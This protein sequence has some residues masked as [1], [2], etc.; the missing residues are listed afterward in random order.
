M[1][2]DRMLLFALILR[3][4]LVASSWHLLV[5]LLPYL[6]IITLSTCQGLSLNTTAFAY[7]TFNS[8]S[9]DISLLTFLNDSRV[10]GSTVLLNADASSATPFRNYT[11]GK[12][13]YTQ[14]VQMRV[15]SNTT[16]PKSVASFNTCFTFSITGEGSAGF[17]FLIATYDHYNFSVTGAG[18]ASM[19]VLNKTHNGDAN[20]HVFA[21]EFDTWLNPEFNDPSDNHI[22]VNVNS[23]NSTA[24]YNLCGIATYCLHLISGDDFTTWIDYDGESQALEVRFTNGSTLQGVARPATPIITVKSLDLSH[25]VNDYMHVGFSGSVGNEPE[26]HHIKSWSFQSSSNSVVQGAGKSDPRVALIAGLA[27]GAALLILVTGLAAAYLL[28][29]RRRAVVMSTAKQAQGQLA[30]GAESTDALDIKMQFEQQHMWLRR[31]T[32]EELSSATNGFSED[33]V[34]GK[35]GYGQVFMG[36][37]RD[38]ES[39]NTI[40]VAMKRMLQTSAQ[41]HV[42]RNFLAEVSIISQIRHRNLVQLYGWCWENEHLLLVYEYMPNNSL[43]K[44]ILPSHESKPVLTWEK[45]HHIMMGVAAAVTY[46]HNGWKKRVLHRD[47]KDSN[48]LLDEEFNAHLGDFGL[49]RFMNHSVTSKQTH[50]AGTFGY[51][52]PEMAHT[53]RTTEKSDVFSFGVLALVVACGR[54]ALMDSTLSE[55]QEEEEEEEYTTLVDFV[56]R[57]HEDGHL[58][59]VADPRLESVFDVDQMTC[60]L[61][62]GLLC[63]HPDPDARPRMRVAHQVLV[64]EASMPSLP[65]SKPS[66]MYGFDRP[67]IFESSESTA[68]DH[69]SNSSRRQGSRGRADVTTTESSD[70]SST[71]AD[72]Q[73]VQEVQ[74]GPKVHVARQFPVTEASVAACKPRLDVWFR[75]FTL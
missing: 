39:M 58:L 10:N 70:T 5:L 25:V 62:L 27:A 73:E 23:M 74:I 37:L 46:L 45:R 18:G 26:V 69:S 52:A 51:M 55:E 36:A 53:G 1:R 7:N 12:L 60:L 61:Q 49:A 59:R 31:F 43:D 13:L 33:R 40:D 54:P 16:A 71:F 22:G 35:G 34:L 57:A 14:P 8:S 47:L 64:G 21:V 75:Q 15:P 17:A 30:E 24:V 63:C 50:L 11:C 44:W 72:V 32:Y 48:V 28:L 19:C 65:A 4:S 6:A 56:W 38:T 41:A 20:N 67:V 42:A 2:S 29:M 9:S 68:D 66:L 3:G